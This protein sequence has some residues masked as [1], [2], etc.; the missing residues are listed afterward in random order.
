ME[1]RSLEKNIV[2][3]GAYGSESRRVEIYTPNGGGGGY[4]IMTGGT[5]DGWIDFRDGRWMGYFNE[6][7]EITGADI[8]ILGDI[9]SEALRMA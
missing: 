1:T 7:S 4:H 8:S 5:Y 3:E 2:F 6:R 9:V